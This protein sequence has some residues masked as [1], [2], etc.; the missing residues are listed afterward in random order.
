MSDDS[1]LEHLRHRVPGF[2]AKG[3]PERLGGGLVNHVW[4][5]NGAPAPVIVKSAQPYVATVP[6]ITLDTRRVI[7]EGRSLSGFDEGGP[8]AGMDDSRIRPPRLIDLDEE[9]CIIVMEDVG[10]SPDLGAW[11]R[12][13]PQ[14]AESCA[15]TGRTIG[16]FIGALHRN[17]YDDQRLA[18]VFD[19]ASIQRARLESQYR[20]IK[21]LCAR[22]GLPDANVLGAEAESFGTLLQAPGRCVIM[23]D[24]WPPSLLISDKGIRI[25]DWEFAHFGRPAQ[26]VAHLAA[27]LWM[28]T[29]R[30]PNEVAAA[31][32]QAVLQG[33]MEEYRSALGS[34]FRTL[35][36]ADGLRESAIHFGAEILVRSVGA[37]KD[38]YLYDGLSLKNA[39]VREAV[40][41]AAAHLRASER[42]DAFAL[43][44][45]G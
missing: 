43:L 8:L 17:T 11:L 28:H 24:L 33:F 35:F 44:K 26:D 13:P 29:H 22:A 39:K 19:N 5:V 16:S 32:A 31:C 18:T 7:I 37:F 14:G 36:G 4:R 1:I 9:R 6:E 2:R 45:S 20:R 34:D 12:R 30:A 40:E 21:D 42:V 15:E 3:T 27:H 25:I 38:G 10:A 23:G 41:V